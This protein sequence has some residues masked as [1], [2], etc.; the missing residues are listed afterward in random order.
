MAL[1][2]PRSIDFMQRIMS[3]FKQFERK[4]DKLQDDVNYHG[5][6]LT[7]LRVMMNNFSSSTVQNPDTKFD[8][9]RHPVVKTTAIQYD[10]NIHADEQNIKTK[11]K[12]PLRSLPNKTNAKTFSSQQS[13]LRT[14]NEGFHVTKRS[15]NPKACMRPRKAE[16]PRKATSLRSQKALE[17]K[18]S[19]LSKQTGKI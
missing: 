7:E 18:R 1:Q 14:N 16:A 19:K 6:T 5:Q 8:S 9:L 10:V 11:L 4:I 15:S 3:S 13:T 2:K 12:N 17:K